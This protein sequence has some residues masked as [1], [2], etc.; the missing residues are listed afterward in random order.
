MVKAAGMQAG[1]MGAVAPW[2]RGMRPAGCEACEEDNARRAWGRR[3]AQHGSAVHG[4]A[5][6]PQTSGKKERCRGRQVERNLAV[7]QG[8]WEGGERHPAAP[9]AGLGSG[10]Q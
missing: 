8:A 6:G 1:K 9:T 5:A 10:A 7:G 2:A 3:G 4:R